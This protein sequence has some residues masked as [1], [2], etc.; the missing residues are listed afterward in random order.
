M[1]KTEKNSPPD[2]EIKAIGVV[3]DALRQLDADGQQRVIDY[4]SRKLNLVTPAVVSAPKRNIQEEAG[5]VEDRSV[6]QNETGSHGVGEDGLEGVSPIAQKWIRRSGLDAGRLS[7]VFS[8]GVDEIDLVAKSVP[9]KSVRARMLNVT[10]LKGVAAYLSGG[11][12]RVNLAQLKDACTHYDAF[13]TNN[14]YKHLKNFAA[15][16]SGSKEM[17]YT[18]TARG[19]TNATTLIKQ[20]TEK[21]K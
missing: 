4:V 6:R 13:D 14:F 10:L 19:F 20:M 2:K 7:S 18:L 3:Y 5:P 15:D 11:V 16:I 1:N 21:Q 12:A 17:G 8:L 9:G